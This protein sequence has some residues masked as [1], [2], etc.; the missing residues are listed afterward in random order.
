[1]VSHDVKK[2]CAM[3]LIKTRK[4]QY[5][6]FLQKLCDIEEDGEYN[7]HREFSKS[8]AESDAECIGQITSFILDRQNPFDVKSTKLRNLLTGKQ[9]DAP[10]A[11]YLLNCLSKGEECYTKFKQE[12]LEDRTLDYFRQYLSHLNC[13]K[14]S[15]IQIMPDIKK[16]TVKAIKL[17]DYA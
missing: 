7:L 8:K 15:T 12:S 17:I 3:E 5:L 13:Q 4:V 14:K 10:L 16:E 1:M 2:Q 9:M 6:R 11:N